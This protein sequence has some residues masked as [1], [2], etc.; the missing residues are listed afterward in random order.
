MKRHNILTAIAAL[1]T[2]AAAGTLASCQN[3]SESGAVTSETTGTHYVSFEIDCE[4][5]ATEEGTRAVMDYDSKQGMVMK[6]QDGDAIGVR[7]KNGGSIEKFTIKKNSISADGKK[8][9]FENAASSL[10]TTGTKDL[11]MAFPY[12]SSFSYDYSSQSGTLADLKNRVLM[13]GNATISDGKIK[14]Q[15][16]VN[17][18]A[19]VRIPKGEQL[20]RGISGTNKATIE[21]ESSSLIN[22]LNI[23]KPNGFGK[24]TVSGIAMTNGKTTDDIYIAVPC[25]TM[26]SLTVTVKYGGEIAAD[27]FLINSSSP[28]GRLF[29]LRF[30]PLVLSESFSVYGVKFKMVG[31]TGG[32][33]TMG[34]GSESSSFSSPAHKV[35][36]SDFLCSET[37]VTQELWNAVM[38]S[39]SNRSKN[40]GSKYLQYPVDRV[41]WSQCVNFA[42]Q[43]SMLTGRNFTLIT[44]AQWE[45]AAGGGRLSHGYIFSG[46]NTAT[47]VGWVKANSKDDIHPVKQLLPNELGIYDMTGNC[48]EWVYDFG[49][50]YPSYAVTDPKSSLRCSDDDIN[51]NHVIRGACWANT[52]T[53]KER[54]LGLPE[55]WD[56]TKIARQGIRLALTPK[57]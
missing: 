51:D 9:I 15:R 6:W 45:Y 21:L 55:D 48:Y 1:L 52:M 54:F 25:N 36:L 20:L 37:E 8:A 30:R 29:T 38:G 56:F 35:T 31:V 28:T 33:F 46:S 16:L 42:A 3:D 13:W 10:P 27:Q 26:A 43:L 32:T 24:I 47:D 57:K 4:D 5:L 14:A 17:T 7:L 22:R 18:A 11:Y 50:S 49:G 2:V 44:E 53:I 19:I 12:Q 41:S 23:G 34:P 40:T 39:K